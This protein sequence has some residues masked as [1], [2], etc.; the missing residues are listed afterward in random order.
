MST[1]S[2]LPKE[3][4]IAVSESPDAR[5]FRNNV[6]TGWQGKPRWHHGE[7]VLQNPRPLHAGLVVGSSDLI[8]WQTVTVTPEMVGSRLAVFSAVEVK[9]GA[10]RLTTEQRAFIAAVQR[11]GGFAGEARSVADAL[12]VL[13]GAQ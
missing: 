12:A 2:D 13:A 9:T 6:G 4:M 5:L 1:A 8:G 11:A 3:I 7:L 10:G